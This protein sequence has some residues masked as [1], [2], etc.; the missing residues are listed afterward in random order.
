M[1]LE[2]YLTIFK[3]SSKKRPSGRSV[4]QIQLV[5]SIQLVLTIFRHCELFPKCFLSR[6]PKRFINE[7]DVRCFSRFT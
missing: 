6:V 5:F 1:W 3:Y 2:E 4:R 7:I